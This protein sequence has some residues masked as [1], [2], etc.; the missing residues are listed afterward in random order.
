MGVIFLGSMRVNNA[1]KPSTERVRESKTI[2][3]ME[4]GIN[5][6]STDIRILSGLHTSSI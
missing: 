6:P 4:Y 2:E 5:L 3:Y 1:Q